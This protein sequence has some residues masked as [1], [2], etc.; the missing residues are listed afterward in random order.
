MD[1]PE[2]AAAPPRLEA[3]NLSWAV[4]ERFVLLD[5]AWSLPRGCLALLTG[6]N[7]AGKSTLLDL[8][9]GVRQ[10]LR[11]HV[12]LDGV[13]LPD[14]DPGHLA[15]RVARLGHKPGLYL[16]LT[17]HENIGLFAR[18]AGQ[19]AGADWLEARL[20]EV[21]IAPRDQHRPLRGLS[22]GMVQRI[23]LARIRSSGADIWLLDE[24]ST[25]LDSDGA[26]VLSGTLAAARARGVTIVV[27]TH[28]PL[29]MRQADQHMELHHGFLHPREVKPC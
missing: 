6:A 2:A 24:P 27:A 23:A 26:A 11:G 5:L 13:P 3:V 7:G 25:G 29:L 9:A 17:A 8:L 15:A 21:G 28:D 10:P 20:D 19:L 14:V 22:R 18:L 12:A 4:G 16:D 1:V